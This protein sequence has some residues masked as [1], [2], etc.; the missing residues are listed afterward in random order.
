MALT[1]SSFPVLDR[2]LAHPLLNSG[3]LEPGFWIQELLCC[4]HPALNDVV[5]VTQLINQWQS[6]N[7]VLLMVAFVP[8]PQTAS[9]EVSAPNHWE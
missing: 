9:Q 6:F 3:L 1:Y 5:K 2:P 4:N 8:L 7:A